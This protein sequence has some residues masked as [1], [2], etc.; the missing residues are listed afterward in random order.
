[1]A[2]SAVPAGLAEVRAALAALDP[3]STAVEKLI[4]L[5]WDNEDVL[6][7]RSVESY[8]VHRKMKLQNFIDSAEALIADG[9][10]SFDITQGDPEF[11]D[12]TDRV[13]AGF[14]LLLQQLHGTGGSISA[15]LSSLNVSESHPA[16]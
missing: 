10:P 3:V 8:V 16:P 15:V 13:I 4:E 11:L 6:I 9:Y 5:K 1:M 14:N 7:L 2:E 12:D